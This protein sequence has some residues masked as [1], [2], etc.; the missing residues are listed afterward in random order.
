MEGGEERKKKS[1]NK[2]N[3]KNRMVSN[4]RYRVL[5]RNKYNYINFRYLLQFGLYFHYDQHIH[6]CIKKIKATIW[7]KR[8]NDHLCLKHQMFEIWLYQ[9][10]LCK[11]N[12][13]GV[14][15]TTRSSY[16][17]CIRNYIDYFTFLSQAFCPSVD[18][19]R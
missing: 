12:N 13:T 18:L 7:F 17:S 2:T 16:N 1:K 6:S 19:W 15:G 10:N 4:S 8:L 3:T 14:S 9:L 11:S 5:N